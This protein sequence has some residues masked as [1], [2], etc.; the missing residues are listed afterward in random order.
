MNWK[1]FWSALILATFWGTPYFDPDFDL[2]NEI[3]GQNELDFRNQ[4]VEIEL[5]TT[6]WHER[7]KKKSPYTGIFQST[8]Y[9]VVSTKSPFSQESLQLQR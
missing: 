5:I 6:F 7:V 3:G 4:R 1:V 2:E 9:T 8:E